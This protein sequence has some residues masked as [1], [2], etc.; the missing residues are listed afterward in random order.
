MSVKSNKIVVEQ[1]WRFCDDT[2]LENFISNVENWQSLKFYLWKLQIFTLPW[3]NKPLD[4]QASIF[5]A[6]PKP[7]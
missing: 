4:M 7:G 3:E 1:F 5:G 6:C 2:M